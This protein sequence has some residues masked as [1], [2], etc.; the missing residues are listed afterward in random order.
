[1]LC[2]LAFRFPSVPLPLPL[3]PSS[4]LGCLTLHQPH[5]FTS[6]GILPFSSALAT[7][8]N[9]TATLYTRLSSFSQE[10]GKGEGVKQLTDN[11]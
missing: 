5:A 3:S 1:M 4:V 9:P 7:K 6:S 11:A 2:N 10:E 8:A